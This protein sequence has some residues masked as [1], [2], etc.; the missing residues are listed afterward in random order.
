MME[1][2]DKRCRGLLSWAAATCAPAPRGTHAGARARPNT[3]PHEHA[4]T[5]ARTHT[6]SVTHTASF[7]SVTH[8]KQAL[9]FLV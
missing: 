1:V 3:R 9:P 2:P 6:H 8:S 7:E 4:R 5:H